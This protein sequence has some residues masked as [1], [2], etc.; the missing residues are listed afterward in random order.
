MCYH[1]VKWLKE[2]KLLLKG[3]MMDQVSF[4]SLD[5]KKD[6][7]EMFP[8][9]D[10][11]QPQVGKFLRETYK[12]DLMHCFVAVADGNHLR[13]Q[14]APQDAMARASFSFQ[15]N[16]PMLKHHGFLRQEL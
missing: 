9:H 3:R 6:M 7:R 4:T 8:S 14:P 1:A 13:Y 16:Y 11:R 2:A 15:V 12:E 5:F 10:I